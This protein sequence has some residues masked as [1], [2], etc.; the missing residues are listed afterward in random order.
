MTF[1]TL[2]FSSLEGSRE[3]RDIGHFNA[4]HPFSLSSSLRFRVDSSKISFFLNKRQRAS[5]YS[6][7][8]VLRSHHDRPIAGFVLDSL[9]PVVQTLVSAIHGIKIYP[10]D[11]GIGFPNTYPL[12]SD[13]AGG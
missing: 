9:A 12:D 6:P 1:R 4:H 3:A 5:G 2:L 8:P 13:L 11:S 7:G 10:V